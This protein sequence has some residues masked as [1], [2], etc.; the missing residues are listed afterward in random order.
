MQIPIPVLTIF[1]T[2]ITVLTTLFHIKRYTNYIIARC[3]VLS[4]TSSYHIIFFS[5]VR[6]HITDYSDI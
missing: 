5:T 6:P 3:Y 1:G 4:T 2:F